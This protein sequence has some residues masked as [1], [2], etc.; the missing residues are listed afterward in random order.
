MKKAF[1]GRIR[2]ACE[3]CLRGR[4]MKAEKMVLCEKKGVVDP[5][6]SC[7]AFRYDPLKR[8]PREAPRLMQ[9]S[10]EDFKL[11]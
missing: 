4:M 3:Y 1:G 5:Q 11:D 10:E 6:H 7:R 9:F 8:V 2:P